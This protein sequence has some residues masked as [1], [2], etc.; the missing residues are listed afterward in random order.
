MRMRIGV[1]IVVAVLTF[2]TIG[3]AEEPPLPL[4]RAAIGV[5]STSMGKPLLISV[6][7]TLAPIAV[8][9]TMVS[10]SGE[11]GM[12]MALYYAGA[13]VGPGTGYFA[14]GLPERG[15]R[16]ILFRAAVT[17]LGALAVNQVFGV[18]GGDYG[19]NA[20]TSAIWT[21]A[22]VSVAALWD[23]ALLPFH[24]RA[25]QSRQQ[26]APADT[27]VEAGLVP[28]LP[29]DLSDEL[30]AIMEAR[31]DAWDAASGIDSGSVRV[32]TLADAF[33]ADSTGAA[34]TL[35][36]RIRR[37]GVGQPGRLAGSLSC[38]SAAL[39]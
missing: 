33:A 17:G 14:A 10:G 11:V 4:E 27:P 9:A 13:V 12:G 26:R 22:G 36:A 15:M 38:T 28:E 3:F 20:F 30:A 8:G 24:I 34:G 6:L 2:P 1:S 31:R 16:G 7:S 23:L 5:D 18:S 29:E 35:G 37:G 39:P 19:A 21:T 32:I 25:K